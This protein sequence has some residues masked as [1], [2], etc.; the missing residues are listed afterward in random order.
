MVWVS[1]A[2]VK[3]MFRMARKTNVGNSGV[4]SAKLGQRKCGIYLAWDSQLCS[5]N[6]KSAGLHRGEASMT[7]RREYQPIPSCFLSRGLMVIYFNAVF[8]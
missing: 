1:G 3:M 7:E 2:P 5:A 8:H 6:L 4:K